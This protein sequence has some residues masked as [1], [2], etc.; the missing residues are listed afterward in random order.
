[1]RKISGIYI[2]FLLAFVSNF[3]F[4]QK[5]EK[6]I[7]YVYN[8]NTEIGPPAW[9]Q[10]QK[11]FEQAKKHRA[12]AIIFKMNTYGGLVD[13]A[14][15]I[16]T[17]ILK[18]KIPVYA[19]VEN[20]AASAGALITIACDSIFMAEGAKIGAATVVTGEGKKAPDKYQ[21]YM[22]ATMRA[23]A[24]A[25]G[26]D[27]LVLGNDTVIKWRR[28]PAIAEAMV[29]ERLK[30]DGIIDSTKVLTFTVN[31]ALKHGYCDRKAESIKDIINT[32]ENPEQYEIVE[33]KPSTIESI[34][35]FLI[36]P[37]IHGFLI[38]IIIGGIYFELQTPGVG[39]PLAAAVSAAVLFFAPLYLEGLAQNW[40][41]LI[42]ILGV[43][44]LALEVFVIPGFGIAGIAGIALAVTGLSMSLIDN[45]IFTYHDITYLVKQIVSAFALVML[46]LTSAIV[47][48]LF[49]GNKIASVPAFR[50]IVLEAEQDPE[51][52]YVSSNLNHLINT[53]AVAVSDLRPG[54]KIMA[55]NEV[56]DAIS[57][58]GEFISKNE[59]VKIVKTEASQVY[60][61]KIN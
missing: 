22:R 4:S 5:N 35:D 1:M 53:E 56:Y 13:A 21:A 3:V 29:D 61:K 38:M 31:E 8:L 43:I 50:K 11:V 41:I 42:F 40:E 27:T 33:Y 44:L 15:S 20:N 7:I 39:F 6:K 18:S 45:I 2:V 57:L 24:E 48:F 17:K 52:G 36:N 37:V 19:F 10:T 60:V 59:K 9:R 58:T 54:G 25:K 30:I 49:L 23:T 55:D 46:S 26:K 32:W 47:L 34:I 28:D 51:K 14:D 16:R 12:T